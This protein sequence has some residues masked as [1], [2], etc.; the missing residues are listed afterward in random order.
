MT[1]AAIA[2]KAGKLEVSIYQ[3][4]E[5]KGKKLESSLKGIDDVIAKKDPVSSFFYFV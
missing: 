1:E 2:V 3:R 4:L 5:C